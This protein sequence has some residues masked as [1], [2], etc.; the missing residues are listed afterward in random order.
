MSGLGVHFALTSDQEEQLLDAVDDDEVM[1][2]ID[3]IEETIG[4]RDLVATD[5]AWDAIHRCLTDG[6]LYGEDMPL[7]LAV[8]GGEYLHEEDDYIVSY[9]TVDEVQEV[10]VALSG[11]D[12]TRLRERYDAIDPDDYDGL[13]G[14]DDFAYTWENFVELIGFFAEAAVNKKAVIFTVDQ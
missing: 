8:L 5:K 2:L 6:T 12:E 11:W 4:E 10:S 1:S 13:K 14:D 9:V 7:S 3:E